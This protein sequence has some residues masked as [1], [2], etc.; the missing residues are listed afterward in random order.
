MKKNIVIYYSKN[1]SNKFLA[2]QISGALDC[3]IEE[4]KPVINLHLIFLMGTGFRIKK[5]QNDI[6]EYERVILC[7]PIWFGRFIYPLRCFVKKYKNKISKL[8]FVTCCMSNDKEKD[9]KSGY[10]MVFNELKKMLPE[11]NIQYTAFPIPLVLPEN[12][13]EDIKLLMGTRLNQENFNGVVLERFNHLIKTLN[14]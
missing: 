6:S 12:K 9:E 11:K 7:G 2:H 13:Q 5:L 4:I 14:V 10:G 3:D 8:S 1:G